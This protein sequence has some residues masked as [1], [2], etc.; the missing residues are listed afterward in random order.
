MAYSLGVFALYAFNTALSTDEHLKKAFGDPELAKIQSVTI[1]SSI[2]NA[3]TNKRSGAHEQLAGIVA[4]V[5][6]YD[7]GLSKHGFLKTKS[8]EVYDN[9]GTGGDTINSFHISTSSAL[10][11]ASQ[12]VKLAKHGSPGGAQ[13]SGSSDFIDYLGI[14]KL[15]SPEII[16]QSIDD[17]NFGYIEAVNTNY[18]KIH[19]LTHGVAHLAHMNDIIGP[20]TNPLKSENLVGKVLGVNQ[21]IGPLVVAKAYQLLNNLGIMHVEKALIVRG[22]ANGNKAK[23]VDEVSI[24]NGGTEAVLFSAGMMEYL[25]IEFS[26]FGFST[27]AKEKDLS[28]SINDAQS[29]LQYTENVL[30]GFGPD[31]ARN[32]LIANTAVLLA[33]SKIKRG[34]TATNLDLKDG[35]EVASIALR[36]KLH[37]QVIKEVREI[38]D[39]YK[40]LK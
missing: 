14:D 21:V 19:V 17:A 4:A 15:A 18:K 10:L 40:V 27:P 39:K 38:Q 32:T 24:M 12:G 23:T 3:A 16:T 34:E 28:P 6:Q 7:I 33:L 37:K 13:R 2:Y 22:Y 26:D 8:K 30:E 31:G 11:A 36:D 25:K 20:M 29:R 1:L 5:F 35:V 9:C